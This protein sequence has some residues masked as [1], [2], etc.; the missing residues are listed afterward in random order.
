M[1][2]MCAF[3]HIRQTGILFES[4]EGERILCVP[5]T[6]NDKGIVFLKERGIGQGVCFSQLTTSYVHI[7]KN[8]KVSEWRRNFNIEELG[9]VDEVVLRGLV[10]R[11]A[12]RVRF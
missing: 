12:I 4:Q 9:K 8:T 10:L 5:F 6:I 7:V 11:N 1:N 3:H 2:I